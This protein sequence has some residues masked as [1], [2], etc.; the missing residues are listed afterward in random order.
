[1]ARILT[2]IWG[3]KRRIQKPNWVKYG[4]RMDKGELD[5][6]DGDKQEVLN[7]YVLKERGINRKLPRILAEVEHALVLCWAQQ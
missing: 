5:N 7:S 2:A 3:I 4:F 6:R 1:M